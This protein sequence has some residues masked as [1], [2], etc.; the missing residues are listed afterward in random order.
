VFQTK[1]LLENVLMINF[2][3]EDWTFIKIIQLVLHLSIVFNVSFEL[4]KFW[5]HKIEP[6]PTLKAKLYI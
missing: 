4:A 3:F 2:Y 6:T 5:V 1:I